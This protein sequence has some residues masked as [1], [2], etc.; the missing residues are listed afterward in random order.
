MPRRLS[1]T[2][3]ARGLLWDLVDV[4][5]ADPADRLD[6]DRP[7]DPLL[8]PLMGADPGWSPATEAQ[9]E[10]PLGSRPVRDADGRVVGS[11]PACS[12]CGGG[13]AE[14]DPWICLGCGSV[15]PGNARRIRFARPRRGRPRPVP[16]KTNRLDRRERIALLRQAEGPACL[17]LLDAR[18]SGDAERASAIER[19]FAL[20]Q[21]AGPERITL[22]EL[23]ARAG[24]EPGVDPRASRPTRRSDR[25]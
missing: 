25:P 5:L 21:S 17:A 3:M 13:V 19:A 15:S 12:I 7:P 11:R 23:H 16:K 14:G 4:S 2:A 8:S 9:R 22:A 18:D 10:R 6:D 1:A 20:Y 24:T